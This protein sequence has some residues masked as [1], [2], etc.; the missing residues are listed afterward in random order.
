MI[1]SGCYA[2]MDTGSTYHMT[3][4]ID[5]R[6]GKTLH[7]SRDSDSLAVDLPVPERLADKSF[8]AGPLQSERHLLIPDL[9]G[10]RYT[11]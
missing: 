11:S 3:C 5:C 8:L 2:F 9:Q 10:V 6:E 4:S 7:T 1:T